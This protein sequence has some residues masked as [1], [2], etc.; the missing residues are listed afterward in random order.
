M[1]GVM[2]SITSAKSWIPSY[3][4][5]ALIWGLSFYFVEIMLLAFHPTVIAFIRL[6]IGA[7][8]LL[9]INRAMKLKLPFVLWKKLFFMGILMNSMPGFLFAFAQDYVSSILAGIINAS[10]PLL[11]LLFL[12]VVFREQKVTSFQIFGLIIGFFGVL[13]VLGVWTG[14][15]SGQ[16]IGVL[17]I[18][19]AATGYGFS[20]P[21]YRRN[22]VPHGYS[23]LSLM[24]LQIA[25]SALQT[26]PFAVFNFQLRGEITPHI[27]LVALMLGGFGSGLAYVLHYKVME[28]AGAAIA[29]S[30]TYL[31]PIVAAVAG[32]MLLNE[33]L[34]WYEFA[35]AAIVVMGIIISRR[36]R[37]VK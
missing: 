22:I 11:T 3:L 32:I 1:A 19:L 20:I 12:M 9:V 25:L 27:I 30:V 35:G 10:T 34:H 36:E 7:I 31:T 13:V 28:R 15:P 8:V 23:P 29:S 24:A 33:K 16:L 26:V 21:Y 2:T 6:S 17:A 14:I 5:V 37:Q 4:V 18:L